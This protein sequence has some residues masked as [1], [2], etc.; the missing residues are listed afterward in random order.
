MM[1]RMAAPAARLPAVD[2]LRGLLMAVMALD[3]VG[4]MVGRFHSQEMWAGAWTRYPSALPF[5]TRAVTH[6]CAP[7]FFLLL[8]AGV[9]L[10]AEARTRAGWAPSQVTRSM[11]TRGLVLVLVSTLLEVP[12]FLIATLTGP[13]LGGNPEFAI[14]GGPERRWVFTVLYA[15]AVSAIAGGLLARARTWTWGVL[16]VAAIGIT[17][18][19]TPGPDQIDVDFSFTRSVLLVSRWSHGVWTQYPWVPWFGI[20]ALGVLLGRALVADE[21]ATYRRLPWI[22]AA[23]LVAGALLRV[24]GGFGNVR[25]PRDGSWIEFLNVLKYPPSLVF[26][27]WTVGLD[28]LLLSA[29][30]RTAAWATAAGRWLEML[31]RAP[32]VFYIA[33]LWLFAVVGAVWFRQGAGYGVV[34]AVWL[35]G[36]APLTLVT[37]AFARFVARRPPDSA[38]RCL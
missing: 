38:W 28:L 25:P 17:A 20:A 7:G 24:A 21:A 1:R 11:V 12:A 5:L 34:Y 30:R 36:L 9:A 18:L 31:G 32:L 3:H 15:L 29:L 4:L 13:P 2:V 26:T 10:Q 8:G 14:P 33:H 22:G 23:A 37:A 35:A 6:L 27:L 16:A 19:T